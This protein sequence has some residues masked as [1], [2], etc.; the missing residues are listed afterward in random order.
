MRNSSGWLLLLVSGCLAA[1][2]AP[3]WSQDTLESRLREALRSTTAQLHSLQDQN[4]TQS[5]ELAKA[6]A[7]ID[8]LTQQNSELTAK[9]EA[10]GA[11]KAAPPPVDED[12]LAK[13]R[14]EVA[15]ANARA[16]A[17]RNQ[18]A[19]SEAALR[20]KTA[21]AQAQAAA[22]AK[23][24]AADQALIAAGRDTNRKL[25]TVAMSIL[26]T[27]KSES[28]RAVWL[29]SYEP[30]LGMA[31]VQVENIMQDYEDKIRDQRLPAAA[32][33]KP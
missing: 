5:A 10:A 2:V 32:T 23:T 18:L 17:L 16:A 1:S 30:L 14:A 27:Y 12:Q 24:I 8:T 28:F 20:A 6:K 4:D 9:L 7:A 33:A 3:A 15:A 19:A 29:K 22:S 13:L 11:M 25:Q 26:D 21:E 31:K